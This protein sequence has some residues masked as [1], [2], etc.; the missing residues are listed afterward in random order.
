MAV[1][2]EV[3]DEAA[4]LSADDLADAVRAGAHLL[5]RTADRDVPIDTGDLLASG[6]IDVVG[7]EAVVSYGDADSW[8]API[9]HEDLE[10]KHPH[11]GSAKW[12]ENAMNNIQPEIAE[13]IAEVVSE[14]LT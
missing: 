2:R 7:D 4:R 5:L 6:R 13:A 3:D 9:V 11:G 8:Y 12:L 10:A 14:K 1:E